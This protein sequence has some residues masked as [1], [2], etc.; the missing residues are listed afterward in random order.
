MKQSSL[1]FDSLDSGDRKRP[2]LAADPKDAPASIVK[3]WMNESPTTDEQKLQRA[4]A[5]R[6]VWTMTAI[7]VAIYVAF[8]LRGVLGK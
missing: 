5:L 4:R 3:T 6:T 8:I 2:S 1:G 7:A